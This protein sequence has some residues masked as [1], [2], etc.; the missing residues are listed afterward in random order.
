MRKLLVTLFVLQFTFCKSFAQWQWLNPTPSGHV[1]KKL[2][3]INNDT[4]YLFNQGGDLFR[5]GNGGVNWQLVQNFPNTFYMDLAFSTGVITGWSNSLYIS[6]DN[7]LTWES[8]S[9]ATIG[10][11]TKVDIISRDTILI[12]TD[13]SKL[14][15]S[16]N[17]G[18]NWAAVNF[19]SGIKCVDFVNSKLGFLSNHEGIYRT[20]DGGINWQRVYTVNTSALVLTIKFYNTLIGFAY[21]DGSEMLKTVDG[22]TTWTSTY[23]GDDM[24]DIFFVDQ[25]NAYAVGEDGAMYRTVN[26]G[27]SWTW[28]GDGP[29]T[30]AHDL[31][32]QYFF[33]ASTGFVVGHRGRILKTT[34]GG[35]TWQKFSPTYIDV[36]EISFGSNNTGYATTWN[37]IYK[38]TDK[39]QTWSELPFSVGTTFPYLDRFEKMHFFNTDTGIVT[40]TRFPLRVFKTVDGGQNWNA[41]TAFPNYNYTTG[42]SFINSATGFANFSEFSSSSSN[43]FGLY[44]TTDAGTSWQLINNTHPLLKIQFLNNQ[45]GYGN[46]YNKLFKTNDGGITWQQVLET[47]NS[48]VNDFYFINTT[49]G[50]ATGNLGFLKMTLDGGVTWQSIATENTFNNH[51][52]KIK[53]FDDKAGYLTNEY[54][55]VY[56]TADGGLTWTR[57]KETFYESRT[58]TFTADS[59]VYIGGLYGSILSNKIAECMIDSLLADPVTACNAKLSA[60]ITADFSRVDSIWFQYG[61]DNFTNT[62]LASPSSISNGK[63]IAMAQASNLTHSSLYKFRVRLLYKGSYR[64]SSVSYFTTATLPAPVISDSITF[65]YSSAF[66][67]NQWFLNGQL[68][69]GAINRLYTPLSSGIYSVQVNENMC[70]SSFSNEIDFVYNGDTTFRNQ[71]V[72][73]PN[74]TKDIFSIKN[75]GQRSL[76]IQVVDNYGRVIYTGSSSNAMISILIKHL[77]SGYLFVKITDLVTKEKITRRILK[78]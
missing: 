22:G 34:N 67:G 35:V 70:S 15:K 5:T 74:P 51:L 8:K 76:E 78:L 77:P 21:R 71:T 4:G 2:T 36:G 13:Q 9:P 39:G 44:K 53:F 1:N 72:L 48:D 6:S 64:Y 10:N 20:T 41:T 25:T 73:Y 47:S 18:S 24:N 28:V 46:Y 14:Y 45:V 26:G 60:K 30:Y 27:T 63:V 61:T 69:A 62:V 68:I 31:F 32:S 75:P 66:S 55:Y 33:N 16:N 65:L 38:T 52:I 49:K 19:N 23:L 56:K 57:Y 54:G 12:M 59:T 43:N 17:R 7:G 11:I 50:F 58:I 40:K 29:R 42:M 37:N 3:F